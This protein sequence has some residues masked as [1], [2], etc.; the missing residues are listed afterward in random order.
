MIEP[1]LVF[2]GCRA[3]GEFQYHRTPVSAR[4]PEAVGG[5]G[6]HLRADEVAIVYLEQL[7]DLDRHGCLTGLTTRGD[8]DRCCGP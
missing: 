4:R 3:G 1:L 2:P 7:D 5:V 6:M 8:P